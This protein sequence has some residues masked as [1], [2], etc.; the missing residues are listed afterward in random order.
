MIGGL[1]QTFLSAHMPARVAP[2]PQLRASLLESNALRCCV[3]KRP[4]VGLHLHH[5]D[6]NRSNSVRENLSVLCVED[7][8][9]HHRP[10]G[11][12]LNPNHL[13]LGAD[14]IRAFKQSWEAF[15]AEARN[16]HPTVKATVTCY[17][18]Y[19]LIHSAQ[20]VLQWPDERIEYER[21]YHLLDCNLDLMT[22]R[23]LEEV[24]SIGQHVKLFLI[25]EPLPVEHCPCCGKGFSRTVKPNVR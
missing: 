5:I 3:C 8:D 19:D 11:Y 10:S 14:R 2:T 1:V 15:V 13:E 17:G 6:G 18:T 21:S 23:L 22:D 4:A 20:L 12:H 7:H 9:R 16:E 25:D 24:M